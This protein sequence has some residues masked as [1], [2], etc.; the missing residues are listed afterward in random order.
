MNT[1]YNHISWFCFL[2]VLF[3]RSLF[4][5][6]FVT[7]SKISLFI[8]FP[9]YS[10]W[11]FSL[12]FSIF[13][14][15]YSLW[16]CTSI[17]FI[18]TVIIVYSF[19]YIVPYFK[20]IYFLWTTVIFVVSMLF[21]VIISNLFYIMLGWDGLGLVSFFLIVFYQN[22]SSIHS[23]IFTLLI[24]RIGDGFYLI[25]ICFIVTLSNDFFTHSSYISSSGLLALFLVITFI[26]K[27]AIYPFSSWLPIAM[28]APTPISA[29]VHSSTLVTS[30]LYLIMRYSYVLYSNVSLMKILVVLCLFTSFYAGFNTIF[31]IDLKKLIALSTLSHLGFIGFS[32]ASGLLVF[33]FFHLLTH[34]LFKSLL[35]ITIGDII[36]ALNHSQDIRYLSSGYYYTPFSCFIIYT[37]LL[38][39]LGI[40]NMSGYF[41]KDL[42][43]EM[44]SYTSFSY[45]LRVILYCNVFFTYFYTYQLFYYS[46]SSCKVVPFQM[47]HATSTLHAS[48]M[49]I[50]G[51]FSILFGKFF[52]DFIYSFSLFVA[53]PSELKFIPLLLNISFFLYLL[54][55]ISFPIFKSA[56]VS[57]YLSSIIFLTP[58]L[59]RV[60]SLFYFKSSFYLV[61]D[62]ELGILNRFLHMSVSRFLSTSCNFIFNIYRFNFLLLA[63]FFLLSS[64]FFIFYC[65]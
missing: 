30:G 57:Y 11:F 58:F 53:V 38:N 34:A 13:L 16:F 20:S 63:I 32:F 43:L 1:V 8:S 64:L 14:D 62:F 33:S 17:I 7:L 4:L 37:S 45:S 48:L 15:F 12:D 60:S 50:L 29:L 24:N 18:S 22:S 42:V 6:L 55:N 21:V 10:L 51:V 40:P 5:S 54:L 25:S 41:S 3:F 36:I 44:F 26:T 39:L 27:S 46:F 31:E 9:V 47:F 2:L 28:A 61:K 35:F 52:I 23:G 56:G 49:F 65:C 19:F 59:I